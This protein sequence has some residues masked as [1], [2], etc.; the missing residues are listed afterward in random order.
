MT[1]QKYQYVTGVVE[2]SH[3]QKGTKAMEKY[4]IGHTLVTLDREGGCNIML[5]NISDE[6]LRFPK[7]LTIAQFTIMNSKDYSEIKKIHP[8]AAEYIAAAAP[9]V[10]IGKQEFSQVTRLAEE[11]N[12][13]NRYPKW[14]N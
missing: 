4:A 12:R 10:N 2:P 3:F 1:P 6:S 14:T 9:Y 13:K 5:T 8:I 7:G 11:D